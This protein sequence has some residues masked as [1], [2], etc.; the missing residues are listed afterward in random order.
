MLLLTDGGDGS[1]DYEKLGQF[2]SY[3]SYEE[4]FKNNLKSSSKPRIILKK[5]NIGKY[6]FDQDKTKELR[7]SLPSDKN[8][9]GI[10]LQRKFPKEE[11]ETYYAGYI[12]SIWIYCQK[13]EISKE[14]EI[15]L[16]LPF[17]PLYI[18]WQGKEQQYKKNLKVKIS[19]TPIF[20]IGG[21]VEKQN[22]K[23]SG[24]VIFLIVVGIIVLVLIFGIVG[25]FIYKKFIKKKEIPFNKH[26][27]QSLLH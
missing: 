15:Q 24:F 17:D 21:V 18:D 4:A 7:N 14:Q 3:S 19:S 9:T 16:S 22:K 27:L 11:N 6:I 23:T 25:L 1:G 13:E 8:A 12:Y 20:L 26:F 5:M 2:S 10:V